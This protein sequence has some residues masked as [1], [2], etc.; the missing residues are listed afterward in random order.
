MVEHRKDQNGAF[1][2]GIMMTPE[3]VTVMK[4]DTNSA[5]TTTTT[6]T[7]NSAPNQIEGKKKNTKY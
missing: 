2:I 3:G 5:T 4:V 7:T 6:T 1:G